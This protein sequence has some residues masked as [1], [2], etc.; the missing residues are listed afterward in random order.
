MQKRVTISIIFEE[1]DSKGHTYCLELEGLNTIGNMEK[2]TIKNVLNAV[3]AYV[4]SLM[5]D[6]NE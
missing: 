1:N 3:Q 2:E 5:K 6:T 4:E